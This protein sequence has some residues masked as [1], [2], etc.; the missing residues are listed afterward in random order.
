VIPFIIIASVMTLVALAWVVVPLVR[1]QRSTAIAREASNVAILRDQSRE[2][3]RDLALGAL[4]PGQHDEARR[5][6]EARVLE[7][8]RPQDTPA[9]TP[10][11]AGRRTLWAIAA[12]VPVAAVALYA[13]W[14]NFDA[15]SPV[16]QVDQTHQLSKEQVSEM[17]AKLAARLEKEPDNADGWMV[18]ARSYYALKRY[19]DAVRAFEHVNQLV[20]DQPGVLVD[21]AD[22]LAATQQSLQGKPI[23]LV[24][25]ALKVDP[26]NWKA[27]ALAGTAAFDRNDYK[28]AVAY[29][30]QLKQVLP[31]E[32]EMS[33]S[34]D[35]SIAE[36]RQLGGLKVAAAPAQSAT[37]PQMKASETAP[38]PPKSSASTAASTGSTAAANNKVEG[39]VTLSPALASRV[40]PDDV[41]FIFARA[42]EGPRMPLAIIKRQ[43][44]ELPAKF[45]LDDSTAMTPNMT[46]T[47]YPQIVVG[48]RVSKS[49]NAMPNAGDLEGYSP[50]VKA[51]ATGLNVVIDRVLQ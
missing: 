11:R 33:K 46:L 36:A 9:V 37:V 5:E 47:S 30:Q 28:E 32:S 40:K 18:L 6:L 2:L 7:E 22:A 1:H 49:G 29:W 13:W 26:T 4:T 10:V 3:E 12:A 16:A 48:A 41:V 38:L 14:G 31:P 42:A 21:Y 44:K 35:A 43:V 19:P 45:A 50:P 20:P 39:T 27:L 8:S 24:M 15:F 25:Q 17:V 51:G 34:V 23:E